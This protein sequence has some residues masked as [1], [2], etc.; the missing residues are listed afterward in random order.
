MGLIT[1]RCSAYRKLP[2]PDSCIEFEATGHAIS[3]VLNWL[4]RVVKGLWFGDVHTITIER[5]EHGPEK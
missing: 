3:K 4:H 2:A 1:F 5:V